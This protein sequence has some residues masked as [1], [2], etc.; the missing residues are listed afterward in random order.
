[1]RIPK[2]APSIRY[3]RARAEGIP[4][5]ENGR[6]F[7]FDTRVIEEAE[8][9]EWKPPMEMPAMTL[10]DKPCIEHWASA[11]MPMQCQHCNKLM[12]YSIVSHNWFWMTGIFACPDHPYEVWV[13]YYPKC[14]GG[15]TSWDQRNRYPQYA[16]REKRIPMASK[17][18][19]LR[20]QVIQ[21]EDE[22]LSLEERWRRDAPLLFTLTPDG[23]VPIKVDL[24]T[25]AQQWW[26]GL[27]N[28][29][30]RVKFAS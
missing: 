6:I 19:L 17:H 1:M 15:D 24:K 12:E 29:V 13:D 16:D 7:F 25:R 5:I 27:V 4:T 8:E 30:P 9:G 3:V 11:H 2:L 14:T 20:H 10:H 26:Q 28:K 23:L 21:N 18:E 22:I